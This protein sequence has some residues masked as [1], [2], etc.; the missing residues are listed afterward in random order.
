MQDP[1][2]QDLS[3]LGFREISQLAD[4]LKLYAENGSDFLGDHVTWEYNPNSDK[5][6]LIDENFNVAMLNDETGKLEEWHNCGYCGHEGFAS[7]FAHE[8][9][10][11]DCKE[12]MKRVKEL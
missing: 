12:E 11:D 4:L 2:I 3:R 10:D 9:K 1:N 6:F 7:N 8:P 5:L